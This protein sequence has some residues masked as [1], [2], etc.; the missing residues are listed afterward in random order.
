MKQS[1]LYIDDEAACLDVFRD[2]FDGEFDVQTVTTADE[3]RRLL[4]EH[5]FDIV[6][7]DQR[8]PGISGTEF[9]REVAANYPESYRVL[10]TGSVTVGETMGDIAAGIVHGFVTKPWTAMDMRQ[11]FERAGASLSQRGYG[12]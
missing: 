3:A 1:I 7:S 5:P 9:L 11:A 4:R 10:L 12:S 2:T 6:I 8:M